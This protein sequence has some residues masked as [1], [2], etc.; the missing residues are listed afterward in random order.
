ML[1]RYW[2]SDVCSSDLLGAQTLADAEAGGVVSGPVDP[3]A[4]RKLLERLGHLPVGDRQVPVGVLS[5]DVLVDAKTHDVLL[6]GSNF[7]SHPWGPTYGSA[8][9]PRS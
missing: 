3:E 1:I 4:G 9:I 5:S 8:P 7:G 6:V 2:S